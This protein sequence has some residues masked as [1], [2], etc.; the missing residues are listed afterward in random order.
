MYIVS[1]LTR[2]IKT[3]LIVILTCCKN[4]SSIVNLIYSGQQCFLYACCDQIRV[5]CEK[6]KK[7]YN[8]NSIYQ[9]YIIFIISDTMAK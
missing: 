1:I 6:E 8:I 9:Y 4:D 5:A 2:L 7:F 3:L